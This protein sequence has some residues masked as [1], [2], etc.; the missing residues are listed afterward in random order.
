MCKCKL[1]IGWFRVVYDMEYQNRSHAINSSMCDY[2][3][4]PRTVIGGTLLRTDCITLYDGNMQKAAQDLMS[5][6]IGTPRYQKK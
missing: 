3:S 6:K 5:T 1:A 2:S 4:N